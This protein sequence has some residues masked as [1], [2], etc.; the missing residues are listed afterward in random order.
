M[1]PLWAIFYFIDKLALLDQIEYYGAY[2]GFCVVTAVEWH[3]LWKP[4]YLM[5]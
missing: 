5:A 2:L 3:H 4:Y 1:A